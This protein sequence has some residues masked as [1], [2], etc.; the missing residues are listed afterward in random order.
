MPG[1]RFTMRSLIFIAFIFLLAS[2]ERRSPGKAAW[3]DFSKQ[4]SLVTC[5]KISG[6]AYRIQSNFVFP[7]YVKGI[8]GE[9]LRLDGY[10]SF[11]A[12]QLPEP[13]THAVTLTGWFA[14]ETF[15]ADTA[16]FF[17]LSDDSGKMYVSATVDQFGMPMLGMSDGTYSKYV[18]TTASVKKFEWIHV[19]VVIQPDTADLWINSQ[20][21]ASLPSWLSEKLWSR[22][23]IG[24]DQKDRFIHDVFPVSGINGVVDEII[25]WDGALEESHIRREHAKYEAAVDPDLAVPAVRFK[26][27][28]NRPKYHLLPAANWTNETHG[29]IYYRGRYHIF[30]QKNGTNLFL[31]QINWGHFSSPDLIHWTEH[32]PAL[33]PDKPYDFKGIWSGHA[34]IDDEG[35]PLIVYT[36]SDGNDNNVNI[37]YPEDDA[38]INWAKDEKNPV[39]KSKPKEFSRRDMRDP[40]VW[41]EGNRWYMIVG[42]GLIENGIGKGSL[43]LYKSEDLTEWQFLHTLFTGDPANDDSGVF[44]EMP[45]FWKI[46]S[47]Y[48]LIVNKVPQPGKPAVALYWI[49]KFENERFVPD[50]KHPQRLELV[51]RLLSP[52][53]TLDNKGRTVA[54]AIIPD[55]TSGEAQLQQGWTHLFSIPRIWSL[56]NNTLVQKPMPELAALRGEHTTIATGEIAGSKTLIRGK[57]QVEIALKLKPVDCEKF[58][59]VI[60]K[61]ADGSEYTKIYYDFESQEM[62]VDSRHSSKNPLIPG[63]VRQGAFSLSAGEEVE[64]HVFIDGSVVEIFINDAA[65]TTRLFPQDEKSTI[66]DLFS[67]GGKLRISAGDLWVL[68]SANITSDW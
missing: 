41:Q 54:I 57:H 39:I 59:L 56:K 7:E 12:G 50:R 47:K 13:K 3:W 37:A 24:R 67:E 30:N 27:D 33:A 62:V 19:A 58:G 32:K 2:V 20:K 53:V 11:I 1:N 44:W 8:Q 4:D 60:G 36:G 43:L 35:K 61:N 9:G 23:L 52:S 18:N 16:G 48:I 10:S 22:I 26:D 5:E 21:V 6:L 49:G 64:L 45:V 63:D 17:A 51:N 55:E 25:L 14:L 42:Y 66:I 68:N 31:G 40:F 65:F 38:L 46:G 15:P 34:I 28:F 29:L